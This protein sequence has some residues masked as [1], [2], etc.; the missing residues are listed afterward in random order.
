MI[1]DKKS[2]AGKSWQID[3]RLQKTNPSNPYPRRNRYL[4]PTEVHPQQ[5]K[6]S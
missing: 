3:L 2:N 1:L 6:P 5:A 4:P